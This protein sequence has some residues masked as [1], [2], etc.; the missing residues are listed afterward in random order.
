MTPSLPRPDACGVVALLLVLATSVVAAPAAAQ[1]G[2]APAAAA[3]TAAV[4]GDWGAYG[5]T[6]LGDRHSPLDQVT[7]ANVAGLKPAWTYHTGEREERYATRANT[8]LE[9]TP[10]MVDGTLFLSTPI[11]RV[12]A[13]D[14][15]TGAERW[16]Y[17]PRIDRTT[18]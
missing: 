10:L 14:P 4:A 6:A 17:D 1:P 12:I 16:T 9:A 2:A 15:V 18:R 11:G 8:A 7:A 13:L 5:R 3:T